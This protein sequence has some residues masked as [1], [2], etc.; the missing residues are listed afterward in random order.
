MRVLAARQPTVS[1]NF[2]VLKARD[3]S[4]GESR[5]RWS[6]TSLQVR[7]DLISLPGQLIFH[8]L[9]GT[10]PSTLSHSPAELV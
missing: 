2:G 9:P 6:W 3:L 4:S 7:L 5:G 8:D 10:P 1:D